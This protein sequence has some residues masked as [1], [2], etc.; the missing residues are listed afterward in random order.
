MIRFRNLAVLCC[1]IGLVAAAPA[2]AATAPPPSSC[3]GVLTTEG[4][5]GSAGDLANTAA[6]VN[7]TATVEC[8]R[9]FLR[10][11]PID[12][13]AGFTGSMSLFVYANG[14]V[15]CERGA[16][17]FN[18]VSSVLVMQAQLQCVIPATDPDRTGRIEGE[19]GWATA[20]PFSC[21]SYLRGDL[22]TVKTKL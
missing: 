16:I 15:K 12:H 18:S 11:P 22:N 3:T 20:P 8:E 2:D 19:V 1:L 6:V 21:C 14:T 4:T 10:T 5:S 7:V 17:P 9:D 13:A